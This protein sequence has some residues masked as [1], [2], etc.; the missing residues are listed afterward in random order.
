MNY[1]NGHKYGDYTAYLEDRTQ[2]NYG[3]LSI[4]SQMNGFKNFYIN[5]EK[6]GQD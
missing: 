4:S 6:L 3:R 5:I 1:D 2:N